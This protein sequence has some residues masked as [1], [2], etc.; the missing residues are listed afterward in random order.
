MKQILWEDFINNVQEGKTY[1]F[2]NVRVIKE[3]KSDKLALGTTL[4]DCTLSESEDFTEPVAQPL[5]LQDSF[6]TT[7]AKIDIK[8]LTT[9]GRYLSCLQCHKKIADGSFSAKILKCRHCDLTQKKYISIEN[10][11]AQ[12][13][14]SQDDN[15][16][17]VTFF[18]EEIKKIFD[19][20]NLPHSMNEEQVTEALL[21]SPILNVTYENKSKIIKQLSAHM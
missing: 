9:F 17:L 12:F 8:G 2:H 1:T 14:V 21:D 5:E 16:I 11:Y 20:L 4:Q 15:Q 3:Y 6:M 19:F 10:C 7:E 13:K 18:Q